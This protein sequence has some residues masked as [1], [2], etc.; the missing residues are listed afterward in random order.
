MRVQE[1]AVDDGIRLYVPAVENTGEGFVLV[2]I[3]TIQ[4]AW[5][6]RYGARAI[7]MDD[8]FNLTTYCLKLATVV[9]AD[10][11]DKG[12]PAAYLLSHQI[13]SANEFATVHSNLITF[14][15]QHNETNMADYFEANCPRVKQWAGFE[16]RTSCVNTSMLVERFHKRIKHEIPDTKGE[17][18]IEL[19][20][21]LVPLME[22]DRS[23]KG[24]AEGRHSLHHQHRPHALALKLFGHDS[25]AVMVVEEGRWALKD[26]KGVHT[27]KQ[28]YCIC[29]PT[30]N[31]HCLRCQ[32]CAYAFMCDCVHD[33]TSGISCAHVHAAIVQKPEGLL[34]EM[35]E[36][37]PVAAEVEV[38][39]AEDYALACPEDS[40]RDPSSDL[41]LPSS[42]T[43][44]VDDNK[45]LLVESESIMAAIG[46][47]LVNM[48]KMPHN[49]S[50]ERFRG[51]TRK[52]VVV[53]Y[54]FTSKFIS[55]AHKVW[56][57][58]KEFSLVNNHLK[59]DYDN[60]NGRSSIEDQQVRN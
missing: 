1:N 21:T 56:F 31:N 33:A 42:S 50:Y 41:K 32:A 25:E 46:T 22:E 35:V 8:T 39:G 54:I 15:N 53:I 3:T 26:K 30:M 34:A 16:R 9:V 7:I 14:L 10:E 2:I 52:G 59:T 44:I 11:W 55:T 51:D 38:N 13:S 5:L 48:S 57:Q 37:L 60:H 17:A 12:L 36:D 4:K 43:E 29:E 49:G 20:I 27:V 6:E 47:Q 58:L 24:L 45:K 18:L 23:I 28:T 19:L 40:I